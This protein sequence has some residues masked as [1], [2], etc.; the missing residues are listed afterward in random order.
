[1]RG[2][3]DTAL[4]SIVVLQRYMDEAYDRMGLGQLCEG[5][6]YPAHTYMGRASLRVTQPRT[7]R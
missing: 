2:E 4:L 6:G 3:N 7:M 5:D 1:M